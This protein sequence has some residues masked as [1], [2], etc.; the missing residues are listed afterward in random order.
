MSQSYISLTVVDVCLY[1]LIVT[2]WIVICF[3]CSHA[4][5][6]YSLR[7]SKSS[8]FQ[9]VEHPRMMFERS[10]SRHD[11]EFEV[12]FDSFIKLPKRIH[13]PVSPI[14]QQKTFQQT[15][16]MIIDVFVRANASNEIN[17]SSILRKRFF[18]QSTVQN[19][20]NGS[21]KENALLLSHLKIFDAYEKEAHKFILDSFNRFSQTKQFQQITL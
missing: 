4:K 9:R 6:F 13:L 3:Q 5:T 1:T 20:L 7:H 8:R 16:L 21:L 10:S 19:I 15:V 17:V 12:G 18:D 2:L 11:H 14:M